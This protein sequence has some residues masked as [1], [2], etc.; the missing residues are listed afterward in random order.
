MAKWVTDES[1]HPNQ[2][3]QWLDNCN[4]Q[5]SISFN[6]SRELIMEIPKHRKQVDV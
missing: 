5:L 6:D 3:G 4:Y 1:W 2:R